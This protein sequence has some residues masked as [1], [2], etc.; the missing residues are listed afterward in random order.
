[1]RSCPGNTAPS[2]CSLLEVLIALSVLAI[3]G[4]VTLRGIHQGQDSLAATGWKDTAMTLGLN[5]LA[6]R[7]LTADAA[8]DKKIA[9]A[10]EGTFSPEHPAMRWRIEKHALGVV[11]GSRTVLLVFQEQGSQSYEL[12]I[13][14][15]EAVE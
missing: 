14:S 12:R 13:E 9:Q 5:L 4:A 10:S 15:F 2:G 11:E 6:E 8:K 1:M 3:L 7:A